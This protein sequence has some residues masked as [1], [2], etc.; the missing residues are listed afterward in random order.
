MKPEDII[1]HEAPEILLAQVL[2]KVHTEGPV[3]LKDLEALTLLKI[4][5]P[6][7]FSI[8]EKKLMYLL[9]LFYKTTEPDDILS[10]SYLIF[11]DA[12]KNEAGH[13]LTPVQASMRNH[14]LSNRY[15]SFSAPT[16]AGKSYLLRELILDTNGDIVIVV[17]SRALITEYLLSVRKLVESRRDV[18]VLQFIDDVNKKKLKEEFL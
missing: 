6:E 1:S 3:E 14:I 17:P 8:Q 2:N 10:F 5:H 13:V 15:F 4:Y 9:G 7:V 12:I 18:L 11:Q 16:S